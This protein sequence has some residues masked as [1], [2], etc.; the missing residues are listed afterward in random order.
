MKIQVIR[1]E[2]TNRGN[3]NQLEVTYKDLD[4]NKTSSKKVM[5]FKT[6]DTYNALKTAS[7]DSQ[8]EITSVK[9]GEYWIWSKAV[10][11]TGGGAS[12]ATGATGSKVSGTPASSRGDWETREERAKKQIYIIKQSSLSV[13]ASILKTDKKQPTTEEVI[14]AAQEFTDWVLGTQQPAAAV[15]MRQAIDEFQDDIPL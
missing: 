12:E 10:P 13:A 15:S 6:K 8:W 4:N 1:V 7:V 11:Y 5:S 9:D 3:Y 2:D 14:A